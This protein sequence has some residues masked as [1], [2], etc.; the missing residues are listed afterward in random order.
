VINDS[1]QLRIPEDLPDGRYPRYLGFYF[2]ENGERPPLTVDGVPQQN[3][4]YFAGW[5]E[6]VR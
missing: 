6:V 1:Y 2:P 3:N 4:A 5:I